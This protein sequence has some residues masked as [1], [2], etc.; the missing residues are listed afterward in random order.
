MS[1]TLAHLEHPASAGESSPP[2]LIAH[3]LFGSARNFNTLGKRLAV[4]RRVVMVDMRNHGLSPWD[5][6]NSYFSM[7]EDLADAVQRLCGGNAVV[8]GHSMGGKAAMVL[9]LSRPELLAGLIVA[10]IAPVPHTH[11]HLHFIKAM[12]AVDLAQ[13]TRR[14]EADPMLADAVPE[15][16]L[17]SFLLQNLTVENGRAEWRINLAALGENMATLLDFPTDL[18]EPAFDGPAYFIHGGASPYVAPETHPR[19]R[20]LFPAAEIEALPG[21]GHWLHAEQPEAFLGK[22]EGWLRTLRPG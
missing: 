15:P 6:D 22:V 2:L 7:A 8:M 5:K 3:G 10:D 20:A 4:T 1:V 18:P 9:A 21:A 13:I 16:M 11:T 19:I 12:Q 14:A 17:R